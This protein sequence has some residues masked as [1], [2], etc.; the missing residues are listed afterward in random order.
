MLADYF[1]EISSTLPSAGYAPLG[2]NQTVTADSTAMG[3]R[4]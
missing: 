3:I 1:T 4:T 2:I